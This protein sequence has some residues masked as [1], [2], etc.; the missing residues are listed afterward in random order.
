M[1]VELLL[2]LG[3]VVGAGLFLRQTVDPLIKLKR[4]SRR[5]ER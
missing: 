3:I 5:E 4:K 2:Q 1:N